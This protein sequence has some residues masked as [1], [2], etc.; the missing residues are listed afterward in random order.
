LLIDPPIVP[1]LRTAGSPIIWASVASAGV[2]REKNG[3]DIAATCVRHLR[4]ISAQVLQGAHSR[5]K[6]SIFRIVEAADPRQQRTWLWI[7]AGPHRSGEKYDKLWRIRLFF[8]GLI[9]FC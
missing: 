2:G 7:V 1:R 6:G 9:R 8:F 3:E 5:K 4:S